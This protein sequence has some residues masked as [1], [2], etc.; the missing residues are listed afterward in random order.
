MAEVEQQEVVAPEA[1]EP[2][3]LAPEGQPES[4]PEASAEDAEPKQ[5]KPPK[6]FTEEELNRKIQK[7]LE[8]ATRSFE[9]KLE[10]ALEAERQRNAPQPSKEASQAPKLD[11]FDNFDDY[12]AAK[13]EFVANQ[14]LEKRIAEVTRQQSEQQNTARRAT[15]EHGWMQKVSQVRNEIDD[16]DDVVESAGV[17]ISNVLG[18]ALME[19]DVGPRL[20]YY[21][22]RHPDEAERINALPPS[23][24]FRAVGRLEAKVEAEKLTTK[25]NAPKPVSPVGAK[26]GVAAKDP[27]KMSVE[28]WTKWR[29]AQLKAARG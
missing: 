12:V 25:S 1:A 20:A 2:A 21:L 5:E 27:D 26:S 10:S 29:N 15:V 17:E 18:E 22:A 9:R 28:E 14:T 7:R 13:A 4:A 11:Q 23:A 19:S 16:F 8:R 3:E 24:V 6:T